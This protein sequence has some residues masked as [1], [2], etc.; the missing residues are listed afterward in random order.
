VNGFLASYFGNVAEKIKAAIRQTLL[1]F[2]DFPP[3]VKPDPK[4]YEV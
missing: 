4:T 3:A 2:S 1:L